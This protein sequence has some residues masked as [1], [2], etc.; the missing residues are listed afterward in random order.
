MDIYDDGA[1]TDGILE[2]GRLSI[3]NE[4]EEEEYYQRAVAGP[5]GTRPTSRDGMSPRDTG[6]NVA[7]GAYVGGTMAAS[8]VAKARDRRLGKPAS[9]SREYPASEPDDKKERER[10]LRLQRELSINEREARRAK[11]AAAASIAEGSGVSPTGISNA[12]IPVRTPH[13]RK[14]SQ[15]GTTTAGRGTVPA[16]TESLATAERAQPVN[17]TGRILRGTGTKRAR[18][19]STGPREGMIEKV[20]AT[21][22]GGALP[23]PNL[24]TQPRPRRGPQQNSLAHHGVYARDF[25]QQ[26]HQVNVQYQQPAYSQPIYPMADPYVPSQ[27]QYAPNGTLLSRSATAPA[28]VVVNGHVQN[29]LPQAAQLVQT[30]TPGNSSAASSIREDS[31]STTLVRHSIHHIWEYWS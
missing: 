30:I 10:V 8:L 6:P 24:Q 20:P 19:P 12:A 3:K 7:R 23:P 1:E 27:P 28:P 11:A 17:S 14:E 31:G 2:R 13:T 5:S 26:Q 22:Y 4:E 9:G 21:K 25:A 16:T 15:A 18:S 29:T